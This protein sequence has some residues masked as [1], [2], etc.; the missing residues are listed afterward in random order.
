L[1]LLYESIHEFGVSD[2]QWILFN[3]GDK[4]VESLSN[5]TIADLDG[6]PFHCF[7]YSTC[8]S[9]Y[10]FTIPDFVFDH[11]KQTGLEDYETTRNWLK[12]HDIKSPETDLLGW[13]GADTNTS[14]SK[15][16]SLD[17]KINFDCEFIIWDRTNPNKLTAK[18]FI[19]FQEQIEKWR[20]LIDMEGVGYSGRL[21]LLLSSPRVV[22][23]QSRIHEEFFFPM[24]KPWVHYVP[25]K[26]DL[27]D[28]MDNLLKV[29]GNLGIEERI[30]FNQRQF[31]QKYLTKDYAKYHIAKILS[32]ISKK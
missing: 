20:F 26:N 29:K 15:L 16:V 8:S 2:F 24:L 32:N 27:S 5:G 9:K 1:K 23:V 14:R 6:N 11:W 4:E 12:R 13:R 22:F 25:V 18:N 17:D 31:S 30:I 19:G 28:L 10:S 7:S 21:K 3:T